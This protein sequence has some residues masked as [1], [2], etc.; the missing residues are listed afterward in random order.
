MA[1]MSD[2]RL[3]N[4]Q[5]VRPANIGILDWFVLTRNAGSLFRHILP[6][7]A[8]PSLSNQLCRL[9]GVVAYKMG[10]LRVASPEDP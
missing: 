1:R 3:G 6:T 7:V 5:E 10:Y 9:W 4:L 2:Y 8:S